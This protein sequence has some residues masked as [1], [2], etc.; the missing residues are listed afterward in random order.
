MGMRH[1]VTFADGEPPQWE[2]VRDFLADRGYLVHLR[3]VGPELV[4]PDDLPPEDWT[5]FRIGRPGAMATL[6]R[7]GQSI[8]CI[9]WGNADAPSQEF[10]NA[11]A[12]AYA[13]LGNGTI[14]CEHGCLSPVEFCAIVTIPEVLKDEGSHLGE[15]LL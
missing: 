2:L 7:D 6:Q 5:E 11:I 1:R 10:W 4:F 12:W 13:M 8:H 15:P 14:E 9:T 3:M